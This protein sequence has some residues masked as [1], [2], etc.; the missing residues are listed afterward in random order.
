MRLILARITLL[1]ISSLVAIAAVFLVLEVSLRIVNP[2]SLRLVGKRI[3]L[4][5]NTTLKNTYNH[6]LGKIR[7]DI[8]IRRNALGFR[9]PNPP[10]DFADH[11][12]IVTVGGS[13]TENIFIT[14]GKTWTDILAK[15]LSES[16]NLLWVNNTGI[17][18]HSTF[19]HIQLLTQYLS[20]LRPDFAIFLIGINDL[21]LDQER[22]ADL[23]GIIGDVSP[24]NN[25]FRHISDNSYAIALLTKY[26]KK[27]DG[28]QFVSM[29]DNIVNFNVLGEATDATPL[30]I[31]ELEQMSQRIKAYEER[32]H[33]I[34]QL[35]RIYGITPV[36]VT[37]PAIY[38]FGIDQETGVDLSTMTVRDFT[39][40]QIIRSGKDKWTLLQMYNQKTIAVAARTGTTVIDLAN[41]M[42]KNTKYYYD[43]IHH[44]EE[45]AAVIGELL[46]PKIC[47]VIVKKFPEHSSSPCY[48]VSKTPVN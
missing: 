11:V 24:P 6:N 32:L 17:D 16:I 48:T 31:E 23:A 15:K 36:F 43:Y 20:I 2:P 26:L 5:K 22:G 42:P 12:T 10:A 35:S 21:A 37:Q 46:Y 4:P 33:E 30:T 40:D 34:I 28:H 8:I 44:T 39:E 1:V 45:G 38:G 3:L 29:T 25:I 27:V 14:E 19:G 47:E 18:G 7:K 13:T 41:L 9:G